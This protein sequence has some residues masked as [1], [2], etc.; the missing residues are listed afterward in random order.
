[1]SKYLGIGLGDVVEVYL[2]HTKERFTV[3][4]KELL[5]ED[6]DIENFIVKG[7]IH[8]PPIC[9]IWENG[10]CPHC[11]NTGVR[12][13]LLFNSSFITKVIKRSKGI[14]YFHGNRF[15]GE[16]AILNK[17]KL[18]DVSK[19]HISGRFDHILKW[20]L[21]KIQRDVFYTFNYDRFLKLYGKTNQGLVSCNNYYVTINKKSFLNW[22]NKNLN[23][24]LMTSK[25]M[26]LLQKKEE[27]YWEK[28][29]LED[30]EMNYEMN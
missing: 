2:N 6:Y 17:F 25:E 7:E 19:K 14:S 3:T 4:I 21:G 28:T 10:V 24:I 30:L 20:A 18:L 26:K 13:E 5:K 23:K 27:E 22:V 15:L 16:T 1:M 9:D 8:N 12:S 29:G 11:N